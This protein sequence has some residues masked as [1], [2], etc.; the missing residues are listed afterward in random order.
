[1]TNAALPVGVHGLFTRLLS[2]AGGAATR[3]EIEEA[4]QATVA[5]S[6]MDRVLQVAAGF[7]FEATPVGLAALSAEDLPVLVLGGSAGVPV[8]LTAQDGGRAA[9]TALDPGDMPETVALA[10]LA[11]WASG[12]A[13]HVQPAEIGRAAQG[14]MAGGTGTGSTPRAE[15]AAERLRALNPLRSLG[16]SGVLWVMV[17]AFVS[18]VLTLATSLFVM[19]VYDRVL[20]NK[21]VESL[22]ALAIGVALA[23]VFDTVLRAARERLVESA[24]RRA[25]ARVTEDIFDQYVATSNLSTRKSVGE[26]AVIMRDFETYRDFMSTA[27]ILTFV[28]LPFVLIFIAV[29][30]K[31]AGLVFLVPLFALPIVIGLVLA[32]QPIVARATRAASRS[33]QSRQG[34]LIEVLS[35]LD[36]LRA[37]G[38]YAMMKNRFLTQAGQ[39]TRATQTS[40]KYNAMV[41]TVIQVVQQVAQVAVI[42]LGFHLFVAQSITMG[43]IIA[44]VILTGRVMGPVARLGQTLGRANMALVAYRNL[45]G[46][47]STERRGAVG[48]AAAQLQGPGAAVPAIEVSNVTLRLAEGGPALFNQLSLRIAPG[49][50]VAIVGRTGSGKSTLLRLMNGLASPETGTV[51]V[52][53]TPIDAIARADMHRR[54]GTV[55]QHPWIAS[56][57]LFDN[58]GLGQPDMTEARVTEALAMAGL[59]AEGG[60][61]GMPLAMPIAD[62][63]ASLSGGERQAVALARAFAFDPPIYLLDE[64]S[65]SMDQSFE[66][67]L[68]EQVKGR[69]KGQTFVIVTHKAR[70]LELCQ[71]VIVMERGRIVGDMPMAEY[72]E[73]TSQH[74]AAAGAGRKRSGVRAVNLG[75]APR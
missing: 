71:R 68:I 61:G 21:A 45:H 58:V 43:A 70:M 65:S 2:S 22:Y 36:A 18:N 47:L 11:T 9:V 39:H 42:V 59:V 28:D 4:W 31:V 50:R 54:I 46:F 41:G 1:M 52:E 32:V 8:L 38:A 12:T 66:N 7:G 13:Y 64:P 67:R 23:L 19:V 30:W 27:M 10:E 63:G 17:A 56:G 16:M 48:A 72:R 33:A 53:G 57:T 60:D 74:A 37:T 20:P 35:G 24:N 69:L 26:L 25:D 55:F 73:K 15:A 34:L 29:I 51:L 3:G 49:E 5:E 62:Q 6:A 44:A 40:R 14:H 75:E